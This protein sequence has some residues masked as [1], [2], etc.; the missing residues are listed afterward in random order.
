MEIIDRHRNICDLSIFYDELNFPIG[1]LCRGKQRYELLLNF[2]ARSNAINR[3]LHWIMNCQRKNFWCSLKCGV[4]M[5]RNV[6]SFHGKNCLLIQFIYNKNIV[7]SGWNYN[8]Y[9]FVRM[10]ITNNTIIC[11]LSISIM[12]ES[13][14]P[15][16]MSWERRYELFLN[17]TAR[18]NAINRFLH[19][20]MNV[21]MPWQTTLPSFQ[22]K[23]SIIT[24]YFL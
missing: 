16:S 1:I 20:I 18:S 14:I 22:L 7:P 3:F 9:H 12:I 8:L 23:Q 21:H 6:I 10:K 24:K 2:T 4:F 17:F 5:R 11:D 13:S 15:N 19:W